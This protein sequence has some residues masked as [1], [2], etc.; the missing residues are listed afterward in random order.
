MREIIAVPEGVTFESLNPVITEGIITFNESVMQRIFEASSFIEKDREMLETVICFTFYLH[1]KIE[2]YNRIE[3][4]EKI[5]REH[6][7]LIDRI[8][9]PIPDVKGH[10]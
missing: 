2:T 8:Q 5:L 1:W 6:P 9:L 10:C 4:F 3:S 7:I